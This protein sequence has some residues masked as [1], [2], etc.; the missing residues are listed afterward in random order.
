MQVGP[1]H[2]A[3]KDTDSR[4]VRED[5]DI[6]EGFD[7][8]VSDNADPK[9]RYTTDSLNLTS[10]AKRSNAKAQREAMRAQIEAA[11]Q[12]PEDTDEG[13]AA[14]SG[15]E[16]YDS[17]DAE[18]HHAY[19]MA[20]TAYGLPTGSAVGDGYLKAQKRP[21]QPREV[22]PIVKL[23]VGLQGLRD[24]VAAIGIEKGRLERRLGEI[25][26]ERKDVRKRQE[27]IQA[28]LAESAAELERVQQQQQQEEAEQDTNNA[29][30]AGAIN[31]TGNGTRTADQSQGTQERG[32]ENVG[33]GMSRPPADEW[34][35]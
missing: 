9:G 30:F 20:Q 16:G 13:S 26:V 8:F 35:E 28:S 27:H 7:E 33:G 29:A 18:R 3:P 34:E 19:E 31:G 4:V 25:A 23:S 2:A 15:G 10:K 24:R 14:G 22:T 32:L 6:A 21:R 17:D 12:S 11:E 1:W 5:E